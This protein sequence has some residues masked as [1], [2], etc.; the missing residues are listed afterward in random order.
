[1]GSGIVWTMKHSY[2]TISQYSLVQL[3]INHSMHYPSLS[4]QNLPLGY[5][6]SAEVSS[7][8]WKGVSRS[9]RERLSLIMTF[10][11][12]HT[13][14]RFLK[15]FP[16]S[17]TSSRTDDMMKIKAARPLLS[18]SVHCE[19]PWI[20][21]EISQRANKL[22]PYYILLTFVKME[23]AIS[24]RWSIKSDFYFLLFTGL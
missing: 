1:M 9:R 22:S 15:S 5:V 14:K 11:H 24:S 18:R 7:W 19:L 10:A 17:G 3:A 2:S 21:L 6:P 13:Q 16:G 12:L 20:L 4:K 23:I 8:F